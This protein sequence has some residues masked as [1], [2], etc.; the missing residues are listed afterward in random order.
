MRSLTSSRSFLVLEVTFLPR[1]SR[2]TASSNSWYRVTIH[3]FIAGEQGRGEERRGEERRGEES[4]GI[5]G[6]GGGGGFW[7]DCLGPQASGQIGCVSMEEQLRGRY[8][9]FYQT[10]FLAELLRTK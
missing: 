8:F 6:G 4:K 10:I 3:P 7:R 1:I 9:F 2:T 5:T